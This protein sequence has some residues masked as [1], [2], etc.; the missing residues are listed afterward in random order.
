MLGLPSTSLCKCIRLCMRTSWR[1]RRATRIPQLYKRVASSKRLSNI[2]HFWLSCR[3]AFHWIFVQKAKKLTRKIWNL[4][5]ATKY[6]HGICVLSCLEQI[7]VL[8]VKNATTIPLSC[9]FRAMNYELASHCV[10]DGRIVKTNEYG[11]WSSSAVWLEGLQF[12]L[13][14][15]VVVGLRILVVSIVEGNCICT[16]MHFNTRIGYFIMINV[17]SD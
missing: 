5:P 3:S 2:F 13:V 17:P 7:V 9:V 10:P 8:E 15:S 16:R 4:N 12:K 6:T 11:R 14:V 1:G